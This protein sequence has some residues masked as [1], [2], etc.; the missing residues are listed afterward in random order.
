MDNCAT[1]HT[2]E[3]TSLLD[4]LLTYYNISFIFLP[5]YSPELN[6]VELAFNKFKL[7]MKKENI[8]NINQAI[9]SIEKTMKQITLIDMINF[10]KFSNY[11]F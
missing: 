5:A 2:E 8:S 4:F 6:P 3:F 10:Y 7:L 1:H 11:K 9:Q